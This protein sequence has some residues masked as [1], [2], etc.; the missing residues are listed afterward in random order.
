MQVTTFENDAGVEINLNKQYDQ[1]TPDKLKVEWEQFLIGVD[2]ETREHQNNEMMH[3]CIMATLT[4][5]V[6]LQLNPH[7]NGY[8]FH[9]QVYAPLLC[10]KVLKLSI[11]DSRATDQQ[12]HINLGGLASYMVSC[13]S[14]IKK[15]H[16]FFDANYSDLIA[17]GNTVDNPFGLLFDEYFAASNHVFVTYMNDK[18]DEYFNNQAH[19]QSLMHDGLMAMAVAMAKYN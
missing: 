10:K 1:I 3:K 14:D 19:M 4:M 6:K 16:Q 11:I 2:K 15:S 17:R 18:Q 13:K 8:I 9:K 5:D 12:L 7:Q